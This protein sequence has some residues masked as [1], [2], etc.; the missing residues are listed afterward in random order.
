MNIRILLALALMFFAIGCFRHVAKEHRAQEGLSVLDLLENHLFNGLLLQNDDNSFIF[1]KLSERMKDANI[2]GISYAVIRNDQVY[3]RAHGLANLKTTQQVNENILF[4]AGSVSKTATG[5]LMARLHEL[6]KIDLDKSIN[7]YF[8]K[9]DI[10]FR[11]K[12][13]IKIA[14]VDLVSNA[15]GISQKKADELFSTLKKFGVISEDNYLSVGHQDKAYV[16]KELLPYYDLL[17]EKNQELRKKHVN[18]IEVNRSLRQIL[19][20]SAG[21]SVHGLPGYP[22][23]E[24]PSKFDLLSGNKI[25][26]IPAIEVIYL[27]Y[28]GEIKSLKAKTKFHYSGGGYV[29]VEI[30][31]EKI[32]NKSFEAIAKEYLF[33]ALG[34]GKSTFEQTGTDSVVINGQTFHKAS[35]YDE[36]GK[37]TGY[38]KY[39]FPAKSMAAMW[40]TP[41]DIARMAIALN[42]SLN[43]QAGSYL[44]YKMAKQM[45]VGA[46]ELDKKKG[47]VGLGVFSNHEK[48]GHSGSN[49]GFLTRY[50]L[51]FDGSGIVYMINSDNGRAIGEEL[52]NANDFLLG[53]LRKLSRYRIETN[54]TGFGV[55][56]GN[57][58][59]SDFQL[60]I[61]L[62]GSRLFAALF[63]KNAKGPVMGGFF[64]IYPIVGNK[65]A[66]NTG[67]PFPIYLKFTD[68]KVVVE[69]KDWPAIEGVYQ[70][71]LRL[72]VWMYP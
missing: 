36:L 60:T 16:P 54:H 17:I 68:S 5:L 71:N 57:Y 66:A 20:H 6:H 4:N 49:P 61:E 33:D 2:P 35:A 59:K 30:L 11:L 47:R 1:G 23:K 65:F 40:S 26:K 53:K 72:G 22:L 70:K 63:H 42:Q 44:S 52:E 46:K 19:S 38:G 48:F 31:L 24:A 41:S 55:L 34:M 45:L 58:F 39:V 14:A 8:K 50:V 37:S 10:D 69:H 51:N 27:P 29:L 64:Q 9:Y 43:G 13:G 32:F 62:R 67:W 15:H 7:D 28:R 21:I 3:A 18:N 56:T 12:L 25:S